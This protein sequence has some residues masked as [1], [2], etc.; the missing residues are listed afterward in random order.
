MIR[1]EHRWASEGP[2]QPRVCLDCH[3]KVDGREWQLSDG[4]VVYLAEGH[5]IGCEASA[6]SREVWLIA[7]GRKLLVQAGLPGWTVGVDRRSRRR[8]GVCNYNRRVVAVSEWHL[9]ESPLDT[10][11]DTLLH[12][13]AHACAAVYDN[14]Y[15]HGDPWKRWCRALGAVPSR[16]GTD[17]RVK[18]PPRAP[19]KWQAVCGRCGKTY[20]RRRITERLRS[21]STCLCVRGLSRGARVAFLL[22]WKRIV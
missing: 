7:T 3:V 1:A 17:Q 20:K 4:R 18:P 9:N 15:G 6:G 14:H 13:V 8:M 5:E 11:M 22:D 12:E 21:G 19:Y 2:G 10:V 16:C